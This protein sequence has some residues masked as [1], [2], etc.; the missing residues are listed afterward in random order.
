MN[1]A[2]PFRFGV[3]EFTTWPW[4]F[5]EDVD[6]Y[7]ALGVDAI[8]VCEFKLDPMRA[9][10][11]L[12]S[13]GERGL[14]ISSVQPRLHSLFP[15]QPRP[16]PRDPAVRMALFRQTIDLFARVA[17]GTTLVTITGAAPDG[18]FR[19]AF[20]TAVDQY[21]RLADY[22]ADR[23]LRVAIEPLNPILMNLDTFICTIPDAMRIVDAVNRPNFGVWLDVWHVWQ[24]PAA[25][26]HIRDCGDRIFGVHVNDW[27]EPRNVADR[28]M[29]GH[30]VIPLIELLRAIRGTGYNGVYALEIFSAESLE[31]SLWKSDLRRVITESR[32]GF[33]AAWQQS[34]DEA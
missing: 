16:E 20:A 1:T 18:N 13:V 22:A 19:Y 2:T 7:A 9:A 21:R 33:V 34:E 12:A 25:A 8:E 15:D 5:E 11:Q 26:K 6:N 32:T 30:G 14:S 3:S 17:A 10:Q 27:H 28:A 23:G 31:D 4:T 24:D 29:I